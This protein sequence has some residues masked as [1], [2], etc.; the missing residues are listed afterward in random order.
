VHPA[1]TLGVERRS[2]GQVVG[3]RWVI[4][5]P[6][7]CVAE[8]V[9][10][11]LGARGGSGVS[12][13]GRRGVGYRT[14]G[15]PPEVAAAAY[16]AARRSSNSLGRWTSASGEGRGMG[17]HPTTSDTPDRRADSPPIND[18]CFANAAF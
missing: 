17:L 5:W 8:R 4:T 16:R 1:D 18:E 14:L 9:K 7:V 12:R 6:C 15:D 2:A 10:R 11:L 13:R 3:R